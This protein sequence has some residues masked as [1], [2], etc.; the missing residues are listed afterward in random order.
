VGGSGEAH[1]EALATESP[2]RRA[3]LQACAVDQALMLCLVLPILPKGPVR[4]DAGL[5][6]EAEALQLRWADVDLKR[7]LLTVPAAYAKNGTSRTVPL[8]SVLRAALIEMK[9]EATSDYVFVGRG[10]KPL[11]S[12][13]NAFETACSEAGSKAGA[14]TRCGTRLPRGSRWPVSM[15]ARSKSSAAGRRWRPSNGIRISRRGTRQKQSNESRRIPP[16][17]FQQP[18][19]AAEG[20]NT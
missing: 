10:G 9:T 5:R 19:V 3:P 2:S 20:G 4:V 18:Q 6:I 14:R 17:L 1:G 12:I 8:N 11:R 7:G 15:P 13:T 16:T